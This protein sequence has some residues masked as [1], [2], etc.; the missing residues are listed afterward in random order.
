MAGT[1]NPI[2]AVLIDGVDVSKAAFRSYEKGY[3]RKTIANADAIANGDWAGQF[4]GLHLLSNNADYDID[5]SDTTTAP[6]GDSYIQDA[7]GILFV[8]KA[9]ET[10][11]P[12]KKLITASGNVTIADDEAADEIEINNTSG[13][14]ISIYLPSVVVRSAP[15]MITEVGGNAATYPITILPKSGSGQTIMT[16]SAWVIDSNGG[17]IKLTPNSAK[18]GYK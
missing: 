13:G 9:V 1:P 17:G 16:G 5:T 10:A 14:A 3:V 4:G 8:R 6:D 18:T 12:L 11:Q 7:N 15:I 2:D